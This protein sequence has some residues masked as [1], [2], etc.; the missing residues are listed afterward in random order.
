M[1]ARKQQTNPPESP[2]AYAFVDGNNLHLSLKKQGWKLDYRAFRRYL[3]DKFNVAKAFYFIGY[4]PT[5][6]GLYKQ[7][8]EWGYIL[9]FKP[10]LHV[11]GKVKGNIDAELVLQAML[12]YDNYDQAV[13]VSGDGYFLCLVEHLIANGKLRKLVVPDD[14]RYSSL[15][16]KRGRYIMGLNKLREKLGLRKRE[17]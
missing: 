16:R 17:A 4:M 13:I 1:A 9:V 12:E 5:N 15:Y 14:R 11:K 3:R 7:L 6:A 2:K 8:Q 10:V